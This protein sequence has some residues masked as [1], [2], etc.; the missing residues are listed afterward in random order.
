MTDFHS[1]LRDLDMRLVW[2]RFDQLNMQRILQL[3]A[4]SKQF[5]LTTRR[6]TEQDILTIIGDPKAFGLYLRL[7][8]RFGDNG[9]IAI[10]IGRLRD[11]ADLEIDTWLMSCRVLGRQVEPTTLNLIV[12]RAKEI[13][14]RRLLGE[15]IPTKK[16]SMVK[17]HYVKLGF[18]ALRS[19]KETGSCNVLDLA[20]FK[21]IETFVRVTSA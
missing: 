16:N 11:N 5:N 17:D 9:I 15:Y 4:R 14:A 19:S 18:T 20:S 6:C 13:G 8:D 7:V 10:I 12:E 1:Y 3:T 21:P 2:S